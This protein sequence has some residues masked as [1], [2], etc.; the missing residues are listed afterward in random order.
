MKFRNSYD[1]LPIPKKLLGC[2]A[3]GDGGDGGGG[4]GNAGDGGGDGGEAK[5]FDTIENETLRTAVSG[6]EDR[7]QALT[8]LG[9]QPPDWRTGIEDE[10]LQSHAKRFNSV[11]D[12]AKSNLDLVSERDRLKNTAIV[13]PGKNA[14]PEEI[15]AFNQKLGVPETPEGYEFPAPAEG[16]Q[17]SDAEQA[18]RKAWAERFHKLGVPKTAAEGIINAFRE[19]MASASETLA[20]EDERF[21]GETETLL[22]REWGQD[23]ARNVAIAHATA[24]QLFGDDIAAMREATTKDNRLLLDQPMMLR[25]LAKVGREMQEGNLGGVSDEERSGLDDQIRTLRT[26]QAEAQASGDSKRANELY[27]KEQALIAR[28]GNRPIVGAAGRAA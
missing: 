17:L 20:Q 10:K 18:S 12:L 21:A 13:V 28:K 7:D 9:Y 4:G 23:Y 14:T 3:E 11:A 15:A 6:F 27:Q 16:E 25:M 2:F 8:A 1:F 24:E 19:D 26:Q 5:W 22:K